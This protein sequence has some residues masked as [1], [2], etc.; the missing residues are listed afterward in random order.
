MADVTATVLASTTTLDQEKFL[1]AKLLQ[2]AHLK[3]VA[4]SVCDKM[5]Q[6]KGTGT[7]SNFIRY[8]RMNL[9]T[10]PLSEGVTP[11]ASTVSVET[12]T[13]G[14]DQWGD[15]I[16]I[17]DIARLTTKHPLVAKAS[18]LLADNAQRVI[19]REI[20]I[21]MLAG[22]N[23]QYGDGTVTTRA[24]ITQA[25]ALT[26]SNMGD[27]IL[28]R[29]YKTMVNNG[30][31]PRSGPS[32]MKEYAKAGPLAG[33]I[34]AGNHYVAIAPVEITR[35]IMRV[36]T[37]SGLWQ[38]VKTYQGAQAIY[39]A[40][41][42]DYLG[43]RW[44][45]SNFMPTFTRLGNKTAALA[46]SGDT[47]AI[48]DAG[49]ITGLTV[50]RATTGGSL[51]STGVYGFKVTRKSLTRGF[52]EAI[53]MIKVITIS[54]GTAGDNEK[55]TFAFPSTAGYVYNLYFTDTDGTNL[56][57]N[58]FLVSENIAASGSVIVTDVTAGTEDSAPVSLRVSGGDA[59]DPDNIYPVYIVSD[60]ALAWVG[61]QQ[62][63]TH[64]TGQEATKSDPLAQRSTVGYKFMAKALILD[65]VRLLRL[66]LPS[67]I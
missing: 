11:T 53:S 37:A 61:L 15:F 46:L 57:A 13:G 66:E 52:E 40:E 34:N 41:V 67:D 63:T 6:P 56:E 49:G 25:M 19:D 54:G 8:T 38:N 48:T 58:M 35:S 36:A 16:A 29:V 26:G 33:S 22:T 31:P 5:Q 43:F 50:T 1:A 28:H 62:L 18:E 9:P 12:V 17:T 14:L 7:T 20:Q 32:N 27:I 21:V 47:T 24:T 60:Q 64:V 4:A 39:N 45:E 30:A 51:A 59:T 42:G 23:V 65:Q 2:L 44:V 55:I 3:L 10:S